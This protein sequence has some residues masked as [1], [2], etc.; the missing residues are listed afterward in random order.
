MASDRTQFGLYRIVRTLGKGATGKVKLVP[1][2]LIERFSVE[3]AALESVTPHKNI[4]SVQANVP[5]A[6]YCPRRKPP[7]EV[8]YVEMEYCS[9][10]ELIGFMFSRGAFPEPMVKRCTLELLEGL[11]QIHRRGLAHRDLKPE[12]ILVTDS[13]EVK[14][15]DFGCAIEV[16]NDGSR[17]CRTYRGTKGYIAPEV[18]TRESYNGQKVDLFALGIILYTL[19][20]NRPPFVQAV[21]KDPFYSFIEKGRWSDFWARNQRVKDTPPMTDEFKGVVERLLCRDPMGRFTCEEMLAHPWMNSGVCSKAQLAVWLNGG[22]LPEVVVQRGDDI[23]PLFRALQLSRNS[24]L[25]STSSDELSLFRHS[26]RTP[27]PCT[28][29]QTAVLTNLHPD[30][31]FEA[32]T[33][34]CARNEAGIKRD[35]QWYRLK[36]RIQG[37]EKGLELAVNICEENQRVKVEFGKVAGDWFQFFEFVRGFVTELA[38]E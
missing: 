2:T 23:D 22:E 27:V 13:F 29:A 4:V 38:E 15:A 12:N 19:Y 1:R 25:N 35:P 30:L 17:L 5:K 24:S 37:G 26:S 11:A 36:A 34:Y 16:G 3:V 20:T 32:V 31:V 6:T 8:A 28:G 21:P 18:I 14:I 33:N 9:R 7:R 10:G